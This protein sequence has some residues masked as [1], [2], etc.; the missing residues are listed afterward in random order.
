MYH[1]PVYQIVSARL[2]EPRRFLQ[3]LTGP[4][5]TGKTTLIRQAME[6]LSIPCL[7]ASADEP[8]LKNREMVFY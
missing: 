2:K 5:Q 3:V 4:R 6:S 8:T 7:Y 1:R